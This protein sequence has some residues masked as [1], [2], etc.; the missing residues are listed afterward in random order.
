MPSVLNESDSN[1]PEEAKRKPS[2]NLVQV[3]PINDEGDS[4]DRDKY[5]LPTGYTSSRLYDILVSPLYTTPVSSQKYNVLSD[6][7]QLSY[8]AC[9]HSTNDTRLNV[10]SLICVSSEQNYI[11]DTANI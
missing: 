2:S 6:L 4:V 9:V 8:C 3:P 5:T 7:T 11:R 1:E 10:S